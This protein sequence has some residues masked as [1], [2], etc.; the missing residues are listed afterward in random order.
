[1]KTN[2]IVFL[3]LFFAIPS[4]YGQTSGGFDRAVKHTPGTT[5]IRSAVAQGGQLKILLHVE[6]AGSYQV[7]VYSSN[8]QLVSQESLPGQA[9]EIVK[10]I[11]FSGKP[12]GVY[13]V[14]LV[15]V[16]AQI[17]RDVLW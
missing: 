15:G 13:V 5:A 11:A 3:F 12:H 14:S 2:F 4:I 1:M 8:G 10:D 16:N 9:G 17:T 7:N 6:E